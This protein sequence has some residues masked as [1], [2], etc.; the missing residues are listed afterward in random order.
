MVSGWQSVFS[1]VRPRIR[2]PFRYQP[3]EKKS[4]THSWWLSVRLRTLSPVFVW[5]AVGALDYFMIFV[6]VAISREIP[7]WLPHFGH[8]K[9]NCACSASSGPKSRTLDK[10][11]PAATSTTLPW[12]QSGQWICF[13]P[14]LFS[15][16]CRPSFLSLPFIFLLYSL[17]HADAFRMTTYDIFSV[18]AHR[19]HLP[20]ISFFYCHVEFYRIIRY[21]VE[22]EKRRKQPSSRLRLIIS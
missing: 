10:S 15:F 17:A 13:L 12:W 8:F 5:R 4:L 7:I 6:Q 16:T 19:W 1:F 11:V 21:S 22:K 20:S 2:F 18:K 14:M 9:N 3:A